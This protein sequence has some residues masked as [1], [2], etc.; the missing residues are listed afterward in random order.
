MRK[1]LK[2]IVKFSRNID[3]ASYTISLNNV[4]MVDLMKFK[5]N[6]SLKG[7]KVILGT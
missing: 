4:F 1:L 7:F 5:S 3:N 2:N 6:K